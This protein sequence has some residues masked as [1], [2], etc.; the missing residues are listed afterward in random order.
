[1]SIHWQ[2][3]KSFVWTHKST[4]KTTREEKLPSSCRAIWNELVWSRPQ[5]GPELTAPCSSTDV[6]RVTVN[7][8]LVVSLFSEEKRPK[9][10][11][12]KQF[13]YAQNMERMDRMQ[14]KLNLS[15]NCS[16]NSALC[17]CACVC[18][19]ESN[20]SICTDKKQ[21]AHIDLDDTGVR[22]LSFS[23]VELKI[24]SFF[25]VSLSPK[26]SNWASNAFS[27]KHISFRDKGR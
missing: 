27:W 24:S 12:E 4:H 16:S 5:P 21:S 14:Q 11:W 20:A 17:T 26:L 15:Q 6:D 25:S 10:L 3:M 13:C 22:W 9:L 8:R 23:F 18:T 1:M 2:W 7:N 19:S